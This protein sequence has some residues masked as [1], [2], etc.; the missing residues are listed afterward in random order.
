L[1]TSCETACLIVYKKDK[2]SLHLLSTDTQK[3][4]F[5]LHQNTGGILPLFDQ[6][7]EPLDLL[8][9][10]TLIQYMAGSRFFNILT[11]YFCFN[12]MGMGPRMSDIYMG[13]IER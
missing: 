5:K 4:F 7:S 11:A 10:D 2:S 1:I 6:D 3:D 8:A 12:T 13:E 9:Q